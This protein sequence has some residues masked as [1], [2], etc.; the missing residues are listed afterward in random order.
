MNSIYCNFQMTNKTF[1]K[2]F[3]WVLRF[4]MLILFCLISILFLASELNLGAIAIALSALTA[5]V[6]MS[7]SVYATKVSS[8]EKADSDL[9]T[10]EQYFGST[11]IGISSVATHHSGLLSKTVEKTSKTH[12]DGRDYVD[13]G[14]DTKYFMEEIDSI[15]KDYI[16]IVNHE[17]FP[18]TLYKIKNNP[19]KAIQDLVELKTDMYHL[20]P[21][22]KS[23]QNTEKEETKFMRYIIEN[24]EKVSDKAIDLKEKDNK[25]N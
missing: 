6:A 24:L 4:L 20:K 19:V 25:E 12:Q 8:D 14:G 9:F 16:D 7:K 10:K 3:T 2:F 22:F 5:S 1:E 15:F 21:R 23:L 18:A 11:M 17:D 13:L